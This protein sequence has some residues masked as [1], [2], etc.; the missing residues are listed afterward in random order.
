MEELPLGD[1]A[2][3]TGTI[4]RRGVPLDLTGLTVIWT[5]VDLAGTILTKTLTQIAPTLGQV[6]LGPFASVDTANLAPG[7]ASFDVVLV[8]GAGNHITA[9]IGSLPLVAHPN[10]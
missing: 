10:Q 2:T 4:T 5:L 8:D 3:Y 7:I 9:E 6:Q 1:A